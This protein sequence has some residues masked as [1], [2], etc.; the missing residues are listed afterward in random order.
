[1]AGKATVTNATGA[2]AINKTTAIGNNFRLC[3]VTVHFNTAPT[4]S[5]ALKV[6][7][8]SAK[9]A[10]YDTVL[11]TINPGAVGSVTDIS[12]APTND[13]VCEAGDEIVVAY[14]NTDTKTYGVRIVTQG[15]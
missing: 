6:T 4:T 12:F 10:A 2:A 11:Y 5:E 7:L 3:N 8:D 14:P 9:G 13:F 15:I 1:M